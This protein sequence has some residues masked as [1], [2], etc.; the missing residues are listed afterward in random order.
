MLRAWFAKEVLRADRTSG[1][2]ALLI[3]PVGS[4]QADYRDAYIL[5]KPR[6]GVDALSLASFMRMP[7]LVVP[8]RS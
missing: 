6:Y 2:T 4:K 8:S 5:P 7:Q 3:L 1:S